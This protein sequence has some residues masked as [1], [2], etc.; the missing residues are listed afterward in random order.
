MIDFFSNIHIWLQRYS[1][2]IA[3]N[4]TIWCQVY[5]RLFVAL[6]CLTNLIANLV[7]PAYFRCTKSKE[8]PNFAMGECVIISFTT[9]PKRIGRVWMV[10][11][12]LLRQ[13]IMPSEIHLWLSKEQLHDESDLPRSLKR[14]IKKG[15]QVHFVDED[16]RSHKKYYYILQIHPDDLIM[17]VDDD[18]LYRSDALQ[19]LLDYHKIY[20]DCVIANYARTIMTTEGGDL[21]PYNTWAQCDK[22]R[23]DDYVFFGSGGGTLYPPHVLHPDVINKDVFLEC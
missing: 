19:K 21:R 2:L 12:S 23:T 7:L 3:T 18:I 9:F 4:S 10:V 11:E 15:L 6:D 17:T 20:P 5:A 16:I 1:G 22:E 14:E 13:K 8:L